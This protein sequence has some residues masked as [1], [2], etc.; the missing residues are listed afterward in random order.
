MQLHVVKFVS[1]ADG[2]SL[3]ARA[4]SVCMC[5]PADSRGSSPK[6]GFAEFC[7]RAKHH[8]ITGTVQMSNSRSCTEVCSHLIPHASFFQG[9][10]VNVE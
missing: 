4:L 10:F 1:E 8:Q 7:S 5:S 3:P 9:L 2:R 6:G